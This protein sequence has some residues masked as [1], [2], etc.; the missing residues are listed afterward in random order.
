MPKK[1]HHFDY[2]YH[3]EVRRVSRNNGIRWKHHWVQVSST[4]AGEYVGFEEIEDGIHNVYFCELLIGRFIEETMK[5]EDVIEQCRYSRPS[6]NA[7]I[8]KHEEKC[9]LCLWDKV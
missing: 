6:L 3:F 2:P 1:L 4:L 8:P 9:P 7:A 5:I